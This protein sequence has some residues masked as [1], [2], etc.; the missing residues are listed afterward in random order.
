MARYRLLRVVAIVNTALLIS[1]LIPWSPNQSYPIAHGQ[2]QQRALLLSETPDLVILEILEEEGYLVEE[3]NSMPE[4]LDQ[5]SQYAVIIADDFQDIQNSLPQIDYYIRYGG[6]YVYTSS[7]APFSD[8][9]NT[10]YLFG[11]KAMGITINGQT[12]HVSVND[13]F[14]TDLQTGDLLVQAP[15]GLL[16]LTD[17]NEASEIVA[18]YD[19]EEVFAYYYEFPGGGKVF[20]QSETGGAEVEDDNIKELLTGGIL[21]AKTEWK[22]PFEPADEGDEET[23]LLPEGTHVTTGGSAPSESFTAVFSDPT[24]L[25]YVFSTPSNKI[26]SIFVTAGSQLVDATLYFEIQD[27]AS[28]IYSYVY[29][30]VPDS[31]T[32]LTF[33]L[34]Q[35]VTLAKLFAS[36]LLDPNSGNAATIGYVT[37]AIQQSPEGQT[38]VKTGSNNEAPVVSAIS[39]LTVAEGTHVNLITNAFDP[40]G[41]I[42]EYSWVQ[43]GGPVVLFFGA[44]TATISFIAPQVNS[45]TTLLFRETVTD[46]DDDSTTQEIS[47]VVTN[48]PSGNTTSQVI[49][50]AGVDRFVLGGSLVVLNGTV[51]SSD[52]SDTRID[53]LL[54]DYAYRWQQVAG[55]SVSLSNANIFNASFIAPTVAEG[56]T[57]S[58][59]FQLDLLGNS[60]NVLLNSDQV[61][62]HVNNTLT[63]GGTNQVGD[64]VP[65]LP[66]I[67]EISSKETFGISMAL[68]VQSPEQIYILRIEGSPPYHLNVPSHSGEIVGLWVNTTAISSTGLE[69][70][71][72]YHD[73]LFYIQLPP[74]QVVAYVFDRSVSLTDVWIG[75]ESLLDG[76]EVDVAYYYNEVPLSPQSLLIP[77]PVLAEGPDST[78]EQDTKSVSNPFGIWIDFS[79][80]TNN[81]FFVAIVAGAPAGIAITFIK[82]RTR[83][84]KSTEDAIAAAAKATGILTINPSE[85]LFPSFD[86]VAG[87]AEKARPVIEELERILG[88]DLDTALTASD[89][90]DKFTSGSRS[91]IQKQS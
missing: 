2:Q 9:E 39:N 55:E 42:A 33:P 61:T 75:T 5:L 15:E 84:R 88:T 43:I 14:G 48:A 29:S 58:L 36:D 44:D 76:G 46:N 20:F 81:L 68:D 24:N 69:L 83:K 23:I 90:L 4:D 41:F 71:F 8:L 56:D 32:L 78:L 18:E 22:G 25:E 86:P 57:K 62:I 26:K 21:W 60:S 47:M 37:D 79:L 51:K 1:A 63:L 67:S 50:Y 7:T 72:G 82:L 70:H 27:E 53:N 3:T 77:S 49:A 89:L 91:K 31:N 6:G 35:N 85:L 45:N 19:S 12:A 34:E 10:Y 52:G 87:E 13:P 66:S 74:N 73:S 54:D 28:N 64:T 16:W 59:T 40:D 11:A 30:V 38:E 65:L 80:D 17:L